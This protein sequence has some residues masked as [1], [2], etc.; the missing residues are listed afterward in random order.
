MKPKFIS[1][2]KWE[3]L[4]EFDGSVS[5]F[6]INPIPALQN[7]KLNKK[8]VLVAIS[9]TSMQPNPGIDI[10]RLDNETIDK[11]WYQIKEFDNKNMIIFGPVKDGEHHLGKVPDR[12]L[13]GKKK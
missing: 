13:G 8:I 1:R 12:V 3:S 11:D 7:D 6:N 4:N 9:G 10:Y 2:E 5:I